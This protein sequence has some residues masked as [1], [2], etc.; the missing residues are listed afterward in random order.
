MG[1]LLRRL[2]GI[3][4]AAMVIQAAAALIDALP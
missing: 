4:A 3:L 2:R 1:L